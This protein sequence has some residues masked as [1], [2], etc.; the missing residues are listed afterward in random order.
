M[1]SAANPYKIE[2]ISDVA[3]CM[4]CSNIVKYLAAYVYVKCPR[5]QEEVW[6]P[7][8][9]AGKIPIPL[10]LKNMFL[11][12]PELRLPGPQKAKIILCCGAVIHILAQQCRLAIAERPKNDQL[13]MLLLDNFVQ[14]HAAL[15]AKSIV[16]RY[17]KCSKTAQPA[18]VKRFVEGSGMFKEGGGTLKPNNV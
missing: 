9:S 13:P 11:G 1:I 10:N 14:E 3:N 17:H 8:L 7:T 6:K 12:W 5:L 18:F 4:L 16:D 15:V 2:H